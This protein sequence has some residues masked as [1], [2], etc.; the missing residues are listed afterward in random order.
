MKMIS[1]DMSGFEHGGVLERIRA[2]EKTSYIIHPSFGK[3]EVF[4]FQG[5]IYMETEG[6]SSATSKFFKQICMK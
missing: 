2:F 1:R 6:H 4:W 5:M 3:A